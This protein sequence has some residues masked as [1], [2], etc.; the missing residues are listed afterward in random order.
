MFHSCVRCNTLASAV[1]MYSYQDRQMWVQDFTH[2]DG[3]AYPMCAAHA[4]RLSP[5]RGWML[6]DHRTVARLFAPLEVA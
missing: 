3:N 6:T 5:P 1:M 4:D 2:T